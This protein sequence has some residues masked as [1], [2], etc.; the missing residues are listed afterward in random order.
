M[1]NARSAAGIVLKDNKLFIA[2]RV[3]GGEMGERWEFP[4]GKVESGESCKET[5]VREYKEEFGIDVTVG[6]HIADASFTHGGKNVALEAWEVFFPDN[7][8]KFILSEHTDVKWVF[9]EEIEKLPFVDSDMLLY[10]DV[11][12]YCMEKKA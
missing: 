6:R 11:L 3:P 12:S 5:L 4:G 8:G 9:P 1:I 10:N 7:P 2:L